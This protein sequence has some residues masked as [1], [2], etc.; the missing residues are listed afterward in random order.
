VAWQLL[1]IVY[2]T[3]HE[4]D[5]EATRYFTKQEVAILEATSKKPLLTVRA[6]TLAL[7]KLV[8]FAPCKRQPLPGIKMLAMAL[9]RFH[10]LKLG[11]LANSS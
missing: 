8:G 11:F 9:E 3:R 7:A 6:A 2:L 1:A 10:Y 5:A 4:P